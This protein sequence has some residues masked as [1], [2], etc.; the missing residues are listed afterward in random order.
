MIT[1]SKEL[2]PVGNYN[3]MIYNLDR[4]QIMSEG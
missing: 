3:I 4:L 1:M 2:L